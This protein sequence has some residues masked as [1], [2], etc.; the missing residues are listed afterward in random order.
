[1]KT[2]HTIKMVSKENGQEVIYKEVKTANYYSGCTVELVLA[3]GNTATFDT[4]K[5]EL[6]DLTPQRGWNCNIQ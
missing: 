4:D 3:D 2:L 6:W 5:W 1:M